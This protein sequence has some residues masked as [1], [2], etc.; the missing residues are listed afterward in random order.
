MQKRTI[1]KVVTVLPK[2]KTEYAKRYDFKNRTPR[3]G[4]TIEVPEDIRH[5]VKCKR[6][7]LGMK[8]VVCMKLKL[9]IKVHAQRLSLFFKRRSPG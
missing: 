9:T 3:L 5:M 7:V 8:K 1:L 2:E 6:D 4:Y